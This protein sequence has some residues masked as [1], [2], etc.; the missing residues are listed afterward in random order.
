MVLGTPAALI[1]ESADH[2]WV[3]YTEGKLA[4][5]TRNRVQFKGMAKLFIF[6]YSVSLVLMFGRRNAGNGVTVSRIYRYS[7][8]LLLY[9]M[10][11][12][13][14]ICPCFGGTPSAIRSGN[15]DK[16]FRTFRRSNQKIACEFAFHMSDV[17]WSALFP[18]INISLFLIR[19][20]AATELWGHG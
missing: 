9:M 19:R 1:C 8:K 5:L 15:E 18:S 11:K 17:F 3:R 13:C 7:R 20:T 10:V 14:P 6:I 2:P 12:G 4:A 16:M